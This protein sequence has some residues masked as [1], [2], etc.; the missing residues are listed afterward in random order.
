MGTVVKTKPDIFGDSLSF[1]T[2]EEKVLTEDLSE[3]EVI[4]EAVEQGSRY[5]ICSFNSFKFDSTIYRCI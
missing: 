4:V 5:K 3:I 1:I 2:V